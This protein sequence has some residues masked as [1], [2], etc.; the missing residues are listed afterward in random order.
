[1]VLDAAVLPIPLSIAVQAEVVAPDCIVTLLKLIVAF[2]LVPACAKIPTD[3]ALFNS[4]RIGSFLPLLIIPVSVMKIY[5]IKNLP[6]FL[7]DLDMRHF[8]D[9]SYQVIPDN[10]V[11]KVL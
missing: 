4:W 9:T 8:Y 2:A 7:L 1:M 5:V 6:S 10:D 11:G 3:H